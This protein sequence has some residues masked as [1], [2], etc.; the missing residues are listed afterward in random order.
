MGPAYPAGRRARREAQPPRA[1]RGKTEGVRGLGR[2][3]IRPGPRVEDE[4][5][6]FAS[7]HDG[8]HEK[9]ADGRALDH[10]LR[11]ER[12]VKA[13][14]RGLGRPR[15]SGRVR[16]HAAHTLDVKAIHHA[17]RQVLLELAWKAD[18][19]FRLVLREDPVLN[20]ERRA[21]LEPPRLE[22]RRVEP[23]R[24]NPLAELEQE[25]AVFARGGHGRGVGSQPITAQ[26]LGHE[27]RLIRFAPFERPPPAGAVENP[28]AAFVSAH[29]ARGD[30][31]HLTREG[32]PFPEAPD[33]RSGGAEMLAPA[34][35]DD[36]A[37]SPRKR[38]AGSPA[39]ALDSVA[40]GERQG[41]HFRTSFPLAGEREM[42]SWRKGGLACAAGKRTGS[43]RSS[44]AFDEPSRP[45]RA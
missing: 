28:R 10:E 37:F 43:A 3:D 26:D 18:A 24:R 17:G 29:H 16:R 40:R 32:A 41:E 38:S 35:H 20:A 11:R 23:E 30:S 31:R 19:V 1:N 34:A 6:C 21:E 8:P 33:K 45:A 13:R 12:A 42:S 15:E 4:P 44:R 7:I 9:K 39:H 25:R 5:S 22:G 2:D 27:L 36:V 14:T